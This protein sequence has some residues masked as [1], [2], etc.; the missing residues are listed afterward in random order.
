MKLRILFTSMLCLALLCL[1]APLASAQQGIESLAN[2]VKVHDLPNGMKF[3]LLERHESPT[4]AFHVY[5]DVGSVDEPIGQTGIAHLYEHMAFKGTTTIGTTD[6]AAESSHFARVDQLEA[7]LTAERDKGA[8]ADQDKVKKLTEDLKTEVDA[9]QK[10]AVQNEFGKLLERN[11]VVNLNAQTERDQ[12]HYFLSL[13]SNKIELWMMLESDRMK[14]EVLR[15]L[16][17]ERD[18]VMEE[19]RRTIDTNPIAKLL[20][21]EMITTAFHAHPYGLHS[22]IGWTSDVSHLTR[23]EVAAFFHK[24]YGGANCTVAIVGDFD[25]AKIIPMIDQYF[26]S[27]AAGEKNPRLVTVE[28]PQE[29]ERRIELEASVQ[30]AV[31]LGYHRGDI[32]D[33]DAIVY[34][35]ISELL[36]SGRTSRLYKN[37]VEG[38][39]VATAV[40]VLPNPIIT[41]GKYP[42][43]FEIAALPLVPAHSVADVEKAIYEEL[44]SL[45]TKPV[46][47]RELQK[48]INQADASFIHSLDDNET[49]AQTLVFTQ[50]LEGDWHRLL[51]YRQRLAAVTPEDVMRVAK[52]TFAKSNR[53]VASI[54]PK[55]VEK[56]ALVDTNLT[57]TPESLSRGRTILDSAIAA[58][59]GAAKVKAIRDYTLKGSTTI[60]FSG[61]EIK[62]QVTRQS[63]LPGKMRADL[64]IPAMGRTITQ[65]LD[66]SGGWM[67]QGGAATE[68]PAE[69]VKT[70]KESFVRDNIATFFALPDGT[71]P[72]AQA[73]A[74][75][76]VDGKAV[77]TIL[78]TAP[79]DVKVT[80]YLDKASHRLLKSS[81]KTRNPLTQQPANAEETYSD[82]R[83]EGGL[84]IPF[85]TV[86]SLDGEKFSDQTLSE[87]AV[88]SGL[89]ASIFEKK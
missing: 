32:L 16:Y 76:T 47:K 4:V 58:V 34:D 87:F 6:Y 86:V 81:Y 88:N 80:L 60:S 49:L 61:Q 41:T 69:A 59:G 83:E 53:T 51:T 46:E 19:V 12:T 71:E 11:G 38:K 40:F 1:I 9:S 31:V 20:L 26:G 55:E 29:G 39:K 5:F 74:D 14:H 21:Q 52:A 25:T 17:K 57:A 70:M 82:Y 48:I 85:H 43:L 68:A 89:D 23:P 79:G 66:G 36:S 45:K 33:K 30:P 42:S 78:V 37:L 84:W 15:E 24:Y 7:E 18:V 64:N 54:V 56:E 75:Q 3:I 73:L 50:G 13:P 72:A 27:V 8:A 10:Y 44:D 65:A 22:G 62:A 77:D 35:V 2:R 67:S 63:L 28:P